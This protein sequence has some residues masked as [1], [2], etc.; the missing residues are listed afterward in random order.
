MKTSSQLEVNNMKFPDAV[1][2]IVIGIVIQKMILIFWPTLL[3][4]IFRD[5]QRG[6]SSDRD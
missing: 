1:T 3:P 5:S 6:L 4:D 2:E